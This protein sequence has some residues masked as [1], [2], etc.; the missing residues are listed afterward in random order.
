MLYSKISQR[1]PSPLSKYSYNAKTIHHIHTSNTNVV[2]SVFDTKRPEIPSLDQSGGSSKYQQIIN[3]AITQESTK[4]L[5]DYLIEQENSNLSLI[6]KQ[7]M[8]QEVLD[9]FK[10]KYKEFKTEFNIDLVHWLQLRFEE[11]LFEYNEINEN[12]THNLI[13]DQIKAHLVC[14]L[15]Y[16]ASYYSSQKDISSMK[17]C[18]REVEKLASQ[19]LNKEQYTQ[20]MQ[21]IVNQCKPKTIKK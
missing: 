12:N 1:P 13:I 16:L 11:I 3:Q 4:I 20:L 8:T 5:S 18:I 9:L 6:N 19:L 7:K 17:Q 10:E 14:L 2:P 21:K 15:S